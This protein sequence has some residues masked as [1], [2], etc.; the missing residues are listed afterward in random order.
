M[1]EEKQRHGDILDIAS[2]T[3]QNLVDDAMAA[4]RLRAEKEAAVLGKPG[5][6]C[7]SCGSELFELARFCDADCSADWQREQDARRRNGR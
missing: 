2:D 1:I 5:W 6:Q 7:L 4:A 3:A